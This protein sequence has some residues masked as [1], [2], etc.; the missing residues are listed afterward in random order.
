MGLCPSEL[1][2]FLFVSLSA[3]PG[4]LVTML[5]T[6]FGEIHYFSNFLYQLY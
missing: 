5:A 3:V 2:V 4:Y 1:C 6:V